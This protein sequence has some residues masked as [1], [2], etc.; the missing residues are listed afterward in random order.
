[1]EHKIK[2]V[3]D[4]L[5]EVAGQQLDWALVNDRTDGMILCIRRSGRSLG[6]EEA[7]RVLEAAWRG[8][9]QMVEECPDAFPP[10]RQSSSA[11]ASP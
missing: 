5:L 4:A 2:F 9:R 11:T 6:D 1:M 10:Q 3:D 8:Y 7:A